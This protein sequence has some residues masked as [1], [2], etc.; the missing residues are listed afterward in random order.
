MPCSVAGVTVNEAD[1]LDRNG[2]SLAGSGATVPFHRSCVI[3]SWK[4]GS[5]S[6]RN[7]FRSVASCQ[8]VRCGS[9]A[10][11]KLYP[12]ALVLM[13]SNLTL[14]ASRSL[15]VSPGGGFTLASKFCDSW[16]LIVCCG[17]ECRLSVRPLGSTACAKSLGTATAGAYCQLTRGENECRMR[18]NGPKPGKNPKKVGVT[19]A[20]NW[21][22]LPWRT[23]SPPVN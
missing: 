11:S 16:T 4:L 8:P 3:D 13:L 7:V 5:K 17:S 2:L 20:L 9:L 15:D 18:E 21:S 19:L 12:I 1:T 22:R 23:N 10:A 6:D 14:R